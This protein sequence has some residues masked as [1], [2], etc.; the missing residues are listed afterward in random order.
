MPRIMLLGPPG[1]GKGT[2]AA[3]IMQTYGIPAISTGDALREQLA[4]GSELG[5]M[6]KSYMDEGKL[7][8]DEIIIILVE[9]LFKEKDTKNGFLLDGFPRTIVQAASLDAFLAEK[10]TPLDKVF[11]LKVPDDVL[12]QRIAHRRICPACGIVYNMNGRKPG[13]EDY[14]DECGTIL[15]QREDDEPATVKKRLDVYNEQTRPLIDYYVKQGILIEI[16]GTKNVDTLQEQIDRELKI[17]A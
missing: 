2:Q 4:Q 8:P 14:C 9:S 13:T 5:R 16:D 12:I 11:F 3:K 7:V 6:A 10:G 17:A 1:S 15:V